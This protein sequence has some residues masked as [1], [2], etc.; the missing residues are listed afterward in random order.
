MIEDRTV[1]GPDGRTLGFSSFGDLQGKAVVLFHGTPGS[2]VIGRI[3]DGFAQEIGCHLVATDRP[4]FGLSSFQPDRKL[5]DHASDVA[6]ICDE[7]GIDRFAVAGVSGG[8]PYVFACAA[9]LPDRVSA[10]AVVS[11]FYGMDD[12]VVSAELPDEVRTQFEQIRAD[13]EASR[14]NFEG[15]LALVGAA[16]AKTIMEQATAASPEWVRTLVASDPTIAEV[17]VEHHREALRPG[18][19]GGVHEMG[20]NTRPWEID[21]GS[22]SQEVRLWHG[23]KDP[24]PRSHIDAVAAALPRASVEWREDC[25]HIDCAL[26]MPGILRWLVTTL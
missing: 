14:P 11:G 7:I 2:R 10:G 21:F 12:P 18:T 1:Q 15:A 9:E 17:Y 22:V 16:D 8:T 13:P 25:G 20:L 6:V 26:L 3:W 19:D 24:V 4:G 5:I 23:G